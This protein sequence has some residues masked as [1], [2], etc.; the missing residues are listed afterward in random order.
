MSSDPPR[1][2]LLPPSYRPTS[3]ETQNFG[4]G[5]STPKLRWVDLCDEEDILAEGLYPYDVDRD[6]ST[7][8]IIMIR[9][10][11]GLYALHDECPH[12][13]IAISESGYIDGEVV[14]C[15]WHHWGFNVETGHH[16]MPTGV[17]VDRFD[18]KVD[19]DRIWIALPW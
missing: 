13:R 5:S 14:H 9:T 1:S 3:Q 19:S 7:Y 2:S 12:R 15:G 17:C 8:P 6:G 16:T 11:G 10:Y 18:V 4:D